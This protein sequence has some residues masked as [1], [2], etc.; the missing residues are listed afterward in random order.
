MN[1][2]KTEGAR[3]STQTEERFLVPSV[4]ITETDDEFVL[5]ADMP[6]VTKKNLEVT[7]EGNE[8]TILGRRPTA[9]V[10]SYLHRESSSAAFRR[11]FVL[12]PLIDGSR[13]RAHAD[14]GVLHIHLPKAEETKPRKVAITD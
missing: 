10:S 13:A 1:T 6:G 4:D 3:V 7:L 14:D 8:L 12:D 5:E 9:T 11:T 2:T